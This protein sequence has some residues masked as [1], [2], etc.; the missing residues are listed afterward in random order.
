MVLQLPLAKKGQLTVI[1][2]NTTDFW[3]WEYTGSEL[4]IVRYM[5]GKGV[6]NRG[7][8]QFLKNM[9][10]FCLHLMLRT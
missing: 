1:I 2:E 8:N 7:S 6:F 9:I 4:S 5:M 3:F 10:H